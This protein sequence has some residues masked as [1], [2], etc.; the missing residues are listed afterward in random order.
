MDA[1]STI[2]KSYVW[3]PTPL[4]Y[5]D[6]QA[7]EAPGK[8]IRRTAF[9]QATEAPGKTQVPAATAQAAATAGQGCNHRHRER[10]HR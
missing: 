3:I 1:S 7:G 8:A 10:R 9:K 5:L 4:V 6:K 2:E